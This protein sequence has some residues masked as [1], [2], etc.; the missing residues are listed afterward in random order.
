MILPGIYIKVYISFIGP[1][2]QQNSIKATGLESW[3][4][5]AERNGFRLGGQKVN[6]RLHALHGED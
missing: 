5:G 4:R 1:L 2:S 6:L 3:P